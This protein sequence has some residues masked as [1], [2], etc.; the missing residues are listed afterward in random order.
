MDRTCGGWYAAG[1]STL[2]LRDSCRLS[3]RLAVGDPV[4]R[5]RSACTAGFWGTFRS[6]TSTL[7]TAAARRR[8][9]RRRR[10]G[11]APAM[12]LRRTCATTSARLSSASMVSAAESKRGNLAFGRAFGVLSVLS[13]LL[14]PIVGILLS[15]QWPGLGRT[16]H[17]VAT[18]RQKPLN[19]GQLKK[20][21]ELRVT[22]TDRAKFFLKLRGKLL[23]TADPEAAYSRSQGH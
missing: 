2:S 1:S 20:L 8:W 23:L 14:G 9:H 15:G 21:D 6:S 16:A 7:G 4:G 12:L 3:G 11:V 18:V 13:L 17:N 19:A 10:R 5:W 22:T